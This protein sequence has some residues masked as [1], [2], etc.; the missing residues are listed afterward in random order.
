MKLKYYTV[1]ICQIVSI[2]L[3]QD[4]IFDPNPSFLIELRIRIRPS[5]NSDPKFLPQ[6]P[7]CN[8]IPDFF[9]G[10]GSGAGAVARVVN[11][12]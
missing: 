10:Y 2:S 7:F 9:Q 6:D 3:R 1:A 11:P 12:G 5:G 4:L 8:P